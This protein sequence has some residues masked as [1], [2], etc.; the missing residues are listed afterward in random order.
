MDNAQVQPDE[1]DALA[2]RLGLHFIRISTKENFNV[3]KVFMYLAKA[4]LTD[5]RDTTANE[6]AVAIGGKNG[7]GEKGPSKEGFAEAPKVT[8]DRTNTDKGKSR[9]KGKK[10]KCV[11][12]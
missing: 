6:A 3:D 1:A 7:S 12:L 5:G 2:R 4:W 8:L 11:I 10:R 9:A